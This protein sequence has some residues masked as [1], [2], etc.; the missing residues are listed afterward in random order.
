MKRILS[1]VAVCVVLLCLTACGGDVNDVTVI[2][3]PSAVY[4]EEDISAAIRVTMDYFQKEFDGCTLLELSYIGDDQLDGYQEFAQNYQA[5]EVI[6]L[7]SSFAVDESGGDGSLNPNS[8]YTGWEWILVRNP[9]ENW[10]HAT[11]GYG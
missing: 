6:V 1:F 2:K 7:T 5:H 9:G 8:T 4:S 10:R 11:H 3:N